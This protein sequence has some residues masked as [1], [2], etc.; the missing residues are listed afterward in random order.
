MERTPK[1][2]EL[3]RRFL[4]DFDIESKLIEL[5]ALAPKQSQI[6]SD[7]YYD[8]V[9]TQFLMINNFWLRFRSSSNATS[10]WELKYPAKNSGA[11][12]ETTSFCRFYEI[13][14][15]EEIVRILIELVAEKRHQIK[16]ENNISTIDE[17]LTLLDLKLVARI[18]SKRKS[19]S[20]CLGDNDNEI[21]VDLD[22]TDFNY[23]VGEIEMI[24]SEVNTSSNERIQEAEAKINALAQKLG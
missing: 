12:N 11:S 24:L 16:L 7:D 8:N 2:L 6:L 13:H 18:N 19:F 9:E 17:L 10:R 23:N 14:A 5:G 20:L 21:H 3:E 15:E 22:E 1:T 4:Y